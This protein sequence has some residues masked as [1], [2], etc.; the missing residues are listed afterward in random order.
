MRRDATRHSDAH[1]LVWYANHQTG[2]Q[3]LARQFVPPSVFQ[4]RLLDIRGLYEGHREERK[5][6]FYS[7]C[8]VSLL[9]LSGFPSFVYLNSQTSNFIYVGCWIAV[10]IIF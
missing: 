8:R 1:V 5:C 2:N 6:S 9:F 4:Y 10:L 3:L 7:A